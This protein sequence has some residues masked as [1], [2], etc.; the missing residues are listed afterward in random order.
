M[1]W[2][3]TS[4]LANTSIARTPGAGG[5]GVRAVARAA[6]AVRGRQ[7]AVERLRHR[8]LLR[9]RLLVGRLVD[10]ALAREDRAAAAVD[11]HA[12]RGRLGAVGLRHD[13]L[14]RRHVPVE[15]R[16]RHRLGALKVVDARE[17]ERLEAGTALL[18]RDDLRERALLARVRGGLLD[19]LLGVERRLRGQR[20]VTVDRA[21]GGD[22][23]PAVRPLDADRHEA[24][25]GGLEAADRLAQRDGVAGAAGQRRG[26]DELE[27]LGRA[28]LEELLV[29]VEPRA[30]RR[31]GAVALHAGRERAARVD[32]RRRRA[33]LVPR[34]LGAQRLRVGTL[35]RGRLQLA[36]ADV[37]VGQ[38]MGVVVRVRP[39]RAPEPPRPVLLHRRPV[40]PARNA[41]RASASPPVRSPLPG[42]RNPDS[43]HIHDR[44]GRV[45]QARLSGLVPPCYSVTPPPRRAARRRDCRLVEEREPGAQPLGVRAERGRALELGAAGRRGHADGER[46]GREL[47]EA[48]L[49]EHAQQPPATVPER[50]CAPPPRRIA[51]RASPLTAA[52]EWPGAAGTAAAG[53]APG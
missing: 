4:A 45:C 33:E 31:G 14:V 35:V 47:D 23:A 53:A 16:E 52:G 26:A 12:V 28:E 38:A 24:A 29:G 30:R 36:L 25:A 9:L 42:S 40:P 15:R 49:R 48:E 39:H 44:T 1:S 11:E 2:S 34:H 10:E 5:D 21:R 37:A 13:R 46:L 6:A 43:A 3:G 41:L 51:A 7:L 32:E 22:D 17:P 18:E 20:L 19:R 27:V 50:G 8:R